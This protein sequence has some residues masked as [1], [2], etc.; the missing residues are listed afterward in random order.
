MFALVLPLVNHSLRVL[1]RCV[2]MLVCVFGRECENQGTGCF[3]ANERPDL[4][5][6][7]G[8]SD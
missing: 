8:M 6:H 3:P 1:I 4:L 5:L 7:E 2:H